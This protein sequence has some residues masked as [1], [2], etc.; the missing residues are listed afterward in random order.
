MRKLHQ[1]I[2]VCRDV[3]KESNR[4]VTKLKQELKEELAAAM[5]EKDNAFSEKSNRLNGN[6]TLK[7][8]NAE[9]SDLGMR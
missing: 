9:L 4:N 2:L 1:Q 5:A 8:H 6:Q 7:S 3:L